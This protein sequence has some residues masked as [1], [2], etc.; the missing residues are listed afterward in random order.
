MTNLTLRFWDIPDDFIDEF[1]VNYE[2]PNNCA[3]KDN[4]VTWFDQSGIKVGVTLE[5][6]NTLQSMP[7]SEVTQ[8]MIEYNFS[9]LYFE[10]ES[11]DDLILFKLTW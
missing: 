9:D 1:F 8:R 7:I 2:N 3:F 11:E 4:I 5:S 10:F 6:P